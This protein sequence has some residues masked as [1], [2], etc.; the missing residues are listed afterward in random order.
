MRI[1]KRLF[2][3]PLLMIPLLLISS[4][5]LASRLEKQGSSQIS[6]QVIQITSHDQVSTEIGIGKI[7]NQA[8]GGFNGYI[9][10]EWFDDDFS[11]MAKQIRHSLIIKGI[12]PERITL[13]YAG[14]S[15][16]AK[17]VSGIQV[18][19][20]KIILQLPECR[21]LAQDYKF[22]L[23]DDTG[24]ALNNNLSSVLVNPYKYYF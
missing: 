12:A 20:Q 8:G 23:Y 7:M 4:Q 14:R 19:V 21:Y 13:A 15:Y 16:R 22:S 3:T 5:S 11:V 24:C 18:H 2:I 10:L 17:Q 9:R 1:E 6:E